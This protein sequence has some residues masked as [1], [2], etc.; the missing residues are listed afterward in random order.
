MIEVAELVVTAL[1]AGAAVGAKDTAS[2]AIK[3]AYAGLKA[4][5]V[6]AL[7][8]SRNVE[9]SAAALDAP[10]D[11]RAELVA[12]LSAADAGHGLELARAAR[13]LLRLVGPPTAGTGK[14]VVNVHD[15]KGVQIGDGNTMTITFRD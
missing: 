9:T 3:D 7:R 1:T 8:G 13:E 6:K 11:H 15:N 4:L 5:T 10:E 14:Y 12:A 2:V